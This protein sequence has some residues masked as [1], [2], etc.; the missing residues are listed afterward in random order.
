MSWVRTN[1]KLGDERRSAALG[2]MTWGLM[3]TSKVTFAAIGRAMETVAKPASRIKQ[4]FDWCHNPRVDPRVA[5]AALVGLLVA[6][7]VGAVGKLSN[8]AIVAV[9]WHDY[10]NGRISGIRVSLI[11][12]SRALP[13]LWREFEKASLKK[14]RK[15]MEAEIL[16][17]LIRLRPPGVQW[18]ILLDS[19]F[20]APEVVRL[21]DSAG[22]FVVR[23]N[24]GILVHSGQRCWTR[25][26]DLPVKVGQIVEFGWLQWNRANPTLLRLVGA[27]LHDL[28]PARTSRRKVLHGKYRYAKPG[29]CVV[30]TNL[31]VD[32]F[33]STGVIRLYARRF[34]IE[35]S[36]RD[37]KNATFGMDMEHVHLEETSTYERLICIVAITEAGLWLVGSEAEARGLHRDLTP[38]RPLDGHRVI[39]LRNVGKLCLDEINSVIDALIKKHL[40]TQRSKIFSVI[41]RRWQDA[42]TKLLLASIALV[43]SRVVHPPDA[44]F[45]NKKGRYPPC[46]KVSSWPLKLESPLQA[47]CAFQEIGA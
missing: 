31:P 21:L 33:S 35:H 26:G 7:A 27:R 3:H 46:C 10:D 43:P 37:I 23:S 41:G 45:H 22:Y 20:R 29:L 13:L 44:C 19:G 24:S 34:E 5:Q 25:I 15:Q 2:E 11:T 47:A 32:E 16:E 8:V 14:R 42:K 28:K 38:S 40:T 36:F 9:D 39:S 17:E 12:G 4:V 1:F 18:L 6:P 30:A